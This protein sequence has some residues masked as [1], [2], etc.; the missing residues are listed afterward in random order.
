MITMD[1]SRLSEL[2]AE[3]A[4]RGAEQAISDL[5]LYTKQ[6]ACEMLGISYNTLQRRIVERKIRIVDGRIPGEAIRQ[7]LS[8]RGRNV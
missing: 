6:Q 4:R 1:E 7:Y 8:E 5:T 3:A 2:L